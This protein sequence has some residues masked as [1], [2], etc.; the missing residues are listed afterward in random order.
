M[1]DKVIDTI[2]HLFVTASLAHLPE[3]IELRY[4]EQSIIP[5]QLGTTLVLERGPNGEAKYRELTLKAPELVEEVSELVVGHRFDDLFDFSG[6]VKA[7]EAAIPRTVFVQTAPFDAAAIVA[8]W[9][10]HPEFGGLSQAVKRHP[11]WIRW[12]SAVNPGTAHT[13]LT[14]QQIADLML[15]GQEDLVEKTWARFFARFR[16][17]ST[18]E[19]QSDKQTGD[20]TLK[21]TFK[22]SGGK[23]GPEM[24]VEVPRD[25]V[26]RIPA[27]TGAWDPGEEPRFE[28]VLRLRIVPPKDEHAPKFRMSWADA[29]GFELAAG[30][31][32][33]DRVRDVFGTTGTK[34]YRGRPESTRYVLPRSEQ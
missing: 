28:A 13:D 24:D 9:P 26:I 23:A 10:E 1:F 34:I 20:E 18:M 29:L 15:D 4:P 17:I 33:V 7:E 8:L 3:K 22:A 27:H 6:Y 16:F 21:L 32:V 5:G 14:H 30:E 12:A 25:I 19:S 31:A 2:R 11:T